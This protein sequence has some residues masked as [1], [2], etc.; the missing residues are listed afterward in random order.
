MKVAIH[1]PEHFPYL[2]FFQKMEI[3][4]IFVILDDVQ[5]SKGGWQNKNKILNNEGI[6]EYFTVP[7]EKKAWKK[8]IMDV[9]VSADK[10]WQRKVVTKL[11]QNLGEDFSYIYQSDLLLDINMLSIEYVRNYL[12]IDVPMIFSSDLNIKTIGTQRLVDICKAVDGNTYIS[13]Q[14]AKN[15]LNESLFDDV[16]L[17]YHEPNVQNCFSAVY[18]IC[19]RIV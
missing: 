5:Y 9:K 13:G 16:E 11:K 3:S 17:I 8:L 14:G 18:N 7:V 19:K 12:K 1:Q 10:L 15:Y 6:E 4:D 2:G